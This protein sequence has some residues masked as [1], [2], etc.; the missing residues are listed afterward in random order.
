M[1]YSRVATILFSTSLQ[2]SAFSTQIHLVKLGFRLSMLQFFVFLFVCV[3]AAVSLQF[4]IQLIHL[5]FEFNV[6]INLIT[7]YSQ[8][9]KKNH[10]L[11]TFIFTLFRSSH[12]RCFIKKAMET[13]VLESLFHKAAY[14]QV[15][16]LKRG[17]NT[18]VFL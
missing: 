17:S 9:G 1:N 18:G 8:S 2:K 3:S 7:Q 5:S 13:S 10:V 12:R 4:C 14:F 6:I 16:N 15:C 11:F